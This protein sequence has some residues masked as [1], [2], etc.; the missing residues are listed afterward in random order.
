M[1]KPNF[2]KL[3]LRVQLWWQI[4]KDLRMSRQVIDITRREQL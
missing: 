2:A 3:H 4:K 1:K